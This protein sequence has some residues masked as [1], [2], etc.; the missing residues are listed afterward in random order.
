MADYEV[1]GKMTLESGSFISS[2]TAA[3]NSLNKLNGSVNNTSNAMKYLKR[4]LL[5]A[6]TALAGLGAAGVKAASDYQQASIAFTTMLGSAEKATAFLQEMRDFAAKTPFELPGLLTGAR[7][8][9]AMGFAADD[10]LPIL[11]NVGDAAAGLGIGAE[12]VDRITLALG[13]MKSKGKVS[14]QELNQLAEAGIPAL[15]YLADAAGV[16]K[17]EILKMGEQGAIPGAEAVDVLIASMGAGSANAMGFGGAMEAQSRTMA[18]LMSTMKDT[19]RDAFVDGFNKYVPA[20]GGTFEKI[21]P[22]IGGVVKGL[23]AAMGF[24]VKNVGGLA[25]ALAKTLGPAITGFIIPALKVMVGIIAAVVLVM[26]KLGDFINANIGIFQTLVTTLGIA[27]LAYGAL[28]VGGYAYIAMAKAQVAWTKLVSIWQ[29]RQAITTNVLAK[30]QR[31]L[32]LTMTFNPIGLI[33]AAVVAL[34]AA[35]VILWNKSDKFREIMVAI[36]KAGLK[37]VGFLIRSLGQYAETIVKLVTGPM[38][39]FLKLLSFISPDAK[40]AYDGLG[41]MTDGIS[42]FFDGMADKVEGAGAALDKFA[43]KKVAAPKTEKGKKKEEKPTVPKLDLGGGDKAGQKALE[44]AMAARKKA[45][46]AFGEMLR[47][48]FGESNELQK[49]LSSSEATVDSIIGQYDKIVENINDRFTGLDQGKKSKL[50]SFITDETAELVRLAKAR[51]VVT[52]ALEDAQEKLK[53]VVAKQAEFQSGITSTIKSFGLAL[54]DISRADSQAV[55][56]VIKSASGLIITQMKSSTSG[57]D[58]ITAQLKDRLKM[59]KDFT[60]NV[61]TLLDKGVNKTYVEQ[62]LAAGPETAGA[63]AALLAKANDAQLNEINTLYSDITTASETFGKDMGITFYDSAV[64][65]AQGLVDGTQAKVDAVNAQMK[66]VAAGIETALTPLANTGK[67][68]GEALMQGLSDAITAKRTALLNQA[69]EVA[70]ALALA[71]K[72]TVTPTST[73]PVVPKAPVVTPAPIPAG[74][75]SSLVSGLG[76]FRLAEAASMKETVPA[77]T[78]NVTINKNVEDAAIEGIMNRAILNAMRAR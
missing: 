9:L 1:K 74:A 51:E 28:K 38:K 64:K 34:T 11:T 53:E 73:T 14:A 17:A 12:G 78:V 68:T 23:V 40:K 22:Q 49:A 69:K 65:M 63:T 16:T 5:A 27:A 42:N 37:V 75:A 72:G 48:P 6:G 10:I 20:I 19:V 62:L 54:A 35:F 61:K 45:V 56:Q 4:G 8:L 39:M 33:L 26:G 55:I 44:D 52:K 43:K 70:D 30:A 67:T 31:L 2:A 24:L 18:G 25:S 50:I 15:Q 60:A 59:I 76:S 36:G 21:I 66:L 41:K 46:A 32:N 77:P 71:L 47:K 58:T 13:Q 29:A 57:V 7:R 3:S